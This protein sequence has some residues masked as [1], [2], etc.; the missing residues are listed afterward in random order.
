M[1]FCHNED[2]KQHVERLLEK[3]N[4]ETLSGKEHEMVI[5]YITANLLYRNAQGP[6]TIQN[7]TNSEF[8]EGKREDDMLII[9]VCNHKTMG[10]FGPTNLIVDNG[11]EILM[12]L[13]YK[14]IRKKSESD[15]WLACNFKACTAPSILTVHVIMYC[16]YCI[17]EAYYSKIKF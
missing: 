11:K 10:L 1:K 17:K 13:Y 3:A 16:L 7:M 6:G 8:E 15:L 12:D 2:I 14:N 9:K 4:N 5:A